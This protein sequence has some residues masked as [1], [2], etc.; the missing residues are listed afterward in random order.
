MASGAQCGRWR[1]SP[2]NR[3]HPDARKQRRQ[4]AAEPRTQRHSGMQHGPNHDFVVVRVSFGEKL[5]AVP[6]QEL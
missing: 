3:A 5:Q 1:K 4:P 2:Q 6:R